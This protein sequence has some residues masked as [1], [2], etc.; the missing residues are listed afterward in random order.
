METQISNK[1]NYLDITI[2]I[3]NNIFRFNIY[4]NPTTTDLI[5]P[6]EPC[7]PIEHKFA[8]IRYLRNRKDTYPNSTEHNQEETK[9]INTIMNN[10]GYTTNTLIRKKRKETNKTPV[11]TLHREITDNFLVR[12]F[13]TIQNLNP[14]LN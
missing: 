2:K 7:H 3:I 13:R 8:A 10:N 5:I 12:H 4:R 1:L 14:I 9:I 6:N 11:A